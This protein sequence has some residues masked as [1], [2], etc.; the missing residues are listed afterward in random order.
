M[1][2][3]IRSSINMLLCS[4]RDFSWIRHMLFAL[5]I[6]AFNNTLVI[7]VPNIRDIFGFIGQSRR[8]PDANTTD[9]FTSSMLN[10]ESFRLEPVRTSG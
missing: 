4:G 1:F 10:V 2:A 3:Q 5:A 8:P 6:L 9:V 7:C